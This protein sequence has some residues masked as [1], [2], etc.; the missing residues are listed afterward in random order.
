M[1]CRIC[2]APVV[3]DG[4]MLTALGRQLGV[5]HPSCAKVAHTGVLTLG[6][7]ALTAGHLVLRD[8][9]PK[10]YQLVEGVRIAV[11]NSRGNF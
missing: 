9:A 11:R 1:N 6:K 10:I 7:M 2:R 4:V 3:A 8:R 5:V